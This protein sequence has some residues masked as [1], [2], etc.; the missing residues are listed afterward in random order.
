MKVRSGLG[1]GGGWGGSDRGGGCTM[2]DDG[3]AAKV[4]REAGTAVG[5]AGA[6]LGGRGA[7]VAPSLVAAEAAPHATLRGAVLIVFTLFSWA[8]VPLFLRYFS[9]DEVRLDPYS[10]NGWRYGISALFWLP[11]LAWAWRRGNLP[12]ALVTASAVPVLFNICGQTAF[13][14]GPKLL[15]PGFFSFVFRVQIV[16]VTLGAYLLFPAERATLR[17]ARY[18]AGVGLVVAGS[19]GLLAFKPGGLGAGATL[20]GVLVALVSGVLFAG[21]GLSVRYYVSRYN[22]IIAFG[23]ICQFTAVGMVVLM[24]TL[25]WSWDR[26]VTAMTAFQVWMLVLSAFIGIA[27]SHVTYYAALRGM[28]V[29]VTVGVI[30]LQ[31][32]LTAVGSL[33]LFDERL[34]AWQW[35]SGFVGIVGALLMLSVNARS[36]HPVLSVDDAAGDDPDPPD[37]PAPPVRTPRPPAQAGATVRP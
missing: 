20:T 37:P 13:A 21:Y 19:I 15:E 31:P 22:P 5:G 16:F 18:W 17:R 25:G 2:S 4:Q 6:A 10:A 24:F 11:V 29:A 8:S 23:V 32:V 26:P 28:G 9:G 33:W 12:W 7:A 30:Q 3:S 14:W 36:K 1:C 35:V 27:I 34:G